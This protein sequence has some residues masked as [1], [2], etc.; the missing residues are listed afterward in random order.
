[1]YRIP[2]HRTTDSEKRVVHYI[3]ERPQLACPKAVW[4]LK[5]GM[6]GL[7]LTKNISL[8]INREFF[9]ATFKASVLA[10]FKNT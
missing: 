6:G 4:E 2:I 8:A 7:D 3:F 1:M 9:E 5:R 10:P